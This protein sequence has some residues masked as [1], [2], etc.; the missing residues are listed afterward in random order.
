[1]MTSVW[2]PLRRLQ[3]RAWIACCAGVAILGATSPS[4]AIPPSSNDGA[5]TDGSHRPD[6]IT[7]IRLAISPPPPDST[8]R[9]NDTIRVTV[10]F[11]KS[12]APTDSSRL[13]LDLEETTRYA[14][15]DRDA[16]PTSLVFTY[17]VQPG[18]LDP[19]GI[20]IETDAL[21]GAIVLVGS[22]DDEFTKVPSPPLRASSITNDSRYKIFARHGHPSIACDISEDDDLPSSSGDI[23]R[24]EVVV[25][26]FQSS[27]A[28][29]LDLPRIKRSKTDTLNACATSDS[30]NV[31]NYKDVQDALSHLN[32]GRR[33]YCSETIRRVVVV[34]D[35]LPKAHQKFKSLMKHQISGVGSLIGIGDDIETL[36]RSEGLYKR[37]HS[38]ARGSILSYADVSRSGDENDDDD[39]DSSREFDLLWR[40]RVLAEHLVFRGNIGYGPIF[41]TRSSGQN[42]EDSCH[43]DDSLSSK[44]VV[45]DDVGI[46]YNIGFQW[47]PADHFRHRLSVFASGGQ[48][49]FSAVDSVRIQDETMNSPSD[50]WNSRFDLGMNIQLF[51]MDDRKLIDYLGKRPAMNAEFGVRLDS[52]YDWQ[53]RWFWRLALDFRELFSFHI[54]KADYEKDRLLSAVLVVEGDS[55]VNVAGYDEWPSTRRLLFFAD[56][57]VDVFT[58][59]LAR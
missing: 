23:C 45:R 10:T 28:D 26:A 9:L 7:V 1:M 58:R 3:A 16:G 47:F 50:Q 51:D 36:L 38:Y 17:V 49:R 55:D 20:S 21:K 35:F 40:T 43:C 59:L 44:N 53:L 22:G 41:A 52:R 39:A 56:T 4:A 6:S 48:M 19:T 57:H 37:F 11:D 32:L 15:Y 42:N 30:T 13:A 12:V 54:R 27:R 14:D 25:A 31:L 34:S 2:S 24:L 5:A 46:Y 33:V 18:D 29:Y 8:F